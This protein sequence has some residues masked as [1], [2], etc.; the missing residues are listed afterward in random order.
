MPGL[1]LYTSNRLEALQEEMAG[2]FKRRPLPPLQKEIIIV[3]S[4]G[5]ERWLNLE[6]AR[7]NGISAHVEYL[8]PKAF[9]YNLF[10]Q[11]LD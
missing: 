11:V 4:R 10:R 2:R 9:V 3:Q 5:M 1:H 8:F 6:M 7:Q